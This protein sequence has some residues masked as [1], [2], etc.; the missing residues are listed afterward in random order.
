MST[1]K[2]NRNRSRTIYKNC[3]SHNPLIDVSIKS[4][5]PDKYYGSTVGL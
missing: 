2:K 4:T 3:A 1:T 5:I